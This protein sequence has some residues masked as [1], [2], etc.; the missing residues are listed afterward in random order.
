MLKYFSDFLQPG[1][2]PKLNADV[3][4]LSASGST[5]TLSSQSTA[6][7]L[8]SASSLTGISFSSSNDAFGICDQLKDGRAGAAMKDKAADMPTNSSDLECRS[9]S[10]ECAASSVSPRVSG[11]ES[12]LSSHILASVAKAEASNNNK[13]AIMGSIELPLEVNQGNLI[14]GMLVTDVEVPS[15]QFPKSL[16]ASEELSLCSKTRINCFDPIEKPRE[17]IKQNNDSGTIGRNDENQIRKLQAALQEE[18]E[19]EDLLKQ[20]LVSLKNELNS[21]VSNSDYWFNQ[22]VKKRKKIE[23]LLSNA[24]DMSSS[25]F[26]LRQE[27]NSKSR[28]MYEKDQEIQRL[29]ERETE[30]EMLLQ[31]VRQNLFKSNEETERLKMFIRKFN[32]EKLRTVKTDQLPQVKALKPITLYEKALESY[33]SKNNEKGNFYTAPKGTESD[34]VLSSEVKNAK[35]HFGPISSHDV[36]TRPPNT[37]NASVCGN[38]VLGKSRIRDE[39]GGKRLFGTP[40]SNEPWSLR[41][42][43]ILNDSEKTKKAINEWLSKVIRQAKAKLAREPKSV[44]FS[45]ETNTV[46]SL[47]RAANQKEGA[48]SSLREVVTSFKGKISKDVPRLQ[49]TRKKS[50][51]SHSRVP[52][53]GEYDRQETHRYKESAPKGCY[54]WNRNDTKADNRPFALMSID[55]RNESLIKLAANVSTDT[56]DSIMD[57][58]ADVSLTDFKSTDVSSADSIDSVEPFCEVLIPWQNLEDAGI[59]QTIEAFKRSITITKQHPDKKV[60][61]GKFLLAN[62]AE[63]IHLKEKKAAAQTS[64][65]IQESY[66]NMFVF[67]MLLYVNVFI[68]VDNRY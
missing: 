40:F 4:N 10:L 31:E 26:L 50:M 39:N 68:V 1:K 28:T 47:K 42:S 65:I 9:A 56:S 41:D 15:K 49:N 5:E 27:I 20:R 13:L 61:L 34:K 33:K 25:N 51:P 46:G 62:G 12:V 36:V 3:R 38:N 23:E 17:S 16:E 32:E 43:P 53:P 37:G 48:R 24:R 11:C 18:T 55:K 45:E 64:G 30:T 66:V 8:S 63:S 7:L 19:S 44:S 57:P 60:H 52:I 21:A 58:F 59:K 29:T 54:D 6:E 14:K 22:C 35:F 67:R 2:D